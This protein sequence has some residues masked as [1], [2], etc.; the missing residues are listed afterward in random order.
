MP[1]MPAPDPTG[2]PAPVVILKFLS[3]FTL[4]LHLLAMN[5][6]V[7]GVTMMALAGRKRQTDP[8][9]DRVFRRLAR[10]LP[11]T[12]SMTITLGVAPLLFVQVIYGQAFYTASVLIAWPWLAIVP[13]V[14]LGYYGLYICQFRPSWLGNRETIV[15]WLSMLAILAVGFVFTNTWTLMLA[16]SIWKYLYD[17]GISG[18]KLN[19]AD[20]TL[21]PRY[22][23]FIVGAFSVGGLAVMLLGRTLKSADEQVSD[24]LQ[25]AGRRW[26]LAAGGVQLIIG[27]WFLFA[28]P[29]R[30]RN[31]FIGGNM[32]DSG[33]LAAGIV[34]AIVAMAVVRRMPGLA[35]LLTGISVFLMVGTRHR[36]RQISLFPD[37]QVNNLQVNPQW[38]LLV[39]FVAVLLVGL[40]T[41]AWMVAAFVRAKP[42]MAG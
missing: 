42:K 18:L 14:M 13:L 32:L 27:F 3:V 28:L 19:M 38:A 12:M 4:T 6:L 36:V 33:V 11:V 15:A 17:A 9:A 7:G 2:L 23:H 40:A 31:A 5:L 22:L 37:L 8:L 30:V 39:V 20:G 35:A 34:L 24:A 26:F 29:D 25:T 10:A 41:V 16:P 21:L 1:V